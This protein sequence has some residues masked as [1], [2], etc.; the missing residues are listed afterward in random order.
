MGGVALKIAIGGF[1]VWLSAQ[2]GNF[3][4]EILLKVRESVQASELL[5][6]DK[7][8]AY[9]SVFGD[10]PSKK[11]RAPRD[12]AEF[13]SIVAEWVTASGGR[14]VTK[15]RWGEPYVYFRF[16]TKDPRTV[17]YL[18]TSKGPDRKLGTPDDIIVERE[19]DHATINRD[20]EKIAESALERKQQLDREVAKKVN[21]LLQEAKKT[22][23]KDP[24]SN[25]ELVELL[26][27]L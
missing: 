20:P 14:N 23:P 21:D 2:M 11:A 3:A 10:D 26:K 9:Q 7:Y 17:H 12:Q 1:L 6:I 15:D 27:Q 16:P 22:P 18:I 24:E 25:R 4:D 13:E 8:V 5:E 19:D